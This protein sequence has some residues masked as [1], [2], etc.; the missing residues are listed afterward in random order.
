V[1]PLV[2]RERRAAVELGVVQDGQPACVDLNRCGPVRTLDDGVAR[3]PRHLLPSTIAAGRAVPTTRPRLVT[4]GDARLFYT[5]WTVGESSIA[6]EAGHPP[7][8][9][10]ASVVKARKAPLL[11]LVVIGFAGFVVGCSSQ[12]AAEQA[13]EQA[14]AQTLVAAAHQAGVASGLTVSVAESMYGTSAPSICKVLD[15]GISSAESLLVS[16]NPS[17]RRAKLVTTDAI[18]YERLVVKTYCPDKLSTYDD[19][20]SD[21]DGTET[22]G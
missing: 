2:R 19:L 9:F 13:E 11:P 18:T 8:C 12:S 6:G 16:G 1:I 7:L 22:T 5:R 20:V 15:D 17:D 3:P 21:I 10:D 4:S 14:K